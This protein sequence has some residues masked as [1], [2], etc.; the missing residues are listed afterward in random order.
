MTKA[1]LE[2]NRSEIDEILH[3]AHWIATKNGAQAR[4]MNEKYPA[5]TFD[6]LMKILIGAKC[7]VRSRSRNGDSALFLVG[8]FE[9]DLKM[10]QFQWGSKR[11][12]SWRKCG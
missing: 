10:L 5:F 12:M 8:E 3:N 11:E 2:L 4:F 9:K 1:L 7:V 6:Q